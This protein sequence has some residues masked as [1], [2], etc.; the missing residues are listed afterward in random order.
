MDYDATDIAATYDPRVVA[1]MGLEFLDLWMNVVSSHRGLL[2]T[3]AYFIDVTSVA[4]FS[5]LG[6]F[7]G[8]DPRVTLAALAH[9]GLN[10]VA[11]PR[12]VDADIGVD[13][14]LSWRYHFGRKPTHRWTGVPMHRDVSQLD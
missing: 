13:S 14:L 6:I 12:L 10:S 3:N 4:R 11:A 8:R 2:D 9:P 5:G 7:R 1:I